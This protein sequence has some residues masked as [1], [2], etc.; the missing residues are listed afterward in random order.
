MT[1][2]LDLIKRC[3]HLRAELERQKDIYKRR[4]QLLNKSEIEG[5]FWYELNRV[6]DAPYTI[7]YEEWSEA[8]GELLKLEARIEYC[9]WQS[10]C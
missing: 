4:E 3:K 1:Y 2:R 7:A 9:D 10:W 5:P 8:Y 6:F